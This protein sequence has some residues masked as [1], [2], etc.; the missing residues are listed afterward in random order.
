MP[1]NVLSIPIKTSPLSS[2]QV[3]NAIRDHID[4]AFH[5][6]HP[7]AFKDDLRELSKVRDQVVRLEVHVAS[8]EAAQRYNAQLVFMGTKFPADVNIAFAWTVSLPTSLT[9]FGT[10][11]PPTSSPPGSPSAPRQPARAYAS[12]S[13]S[14]L[15]VAQ[16]D[17]HYERAAVLFSLAALS[18]AIGASESRGEGESIKRAIAAFQVRF[19]FALGG[20]C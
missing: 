14:T 11:L 5:D 19:L 15:T 10:Q 1:R 12:T 9:F 18:S 4:E 16:P 17:I 20:E 13:G 7:D 2:S 3:S 8:I 6:T